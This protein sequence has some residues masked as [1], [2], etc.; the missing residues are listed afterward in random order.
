[1]ILGMYYLQT[2]FHKSIET[3]RDVSALHLIYYSGHSGIKKKTKKQQHTTLGKPVLVQQV[4][5]S[6][7]NQLGCL[8]A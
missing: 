1:M 2:D 8:R 7:A 4:C 6:L 5:P 3:V